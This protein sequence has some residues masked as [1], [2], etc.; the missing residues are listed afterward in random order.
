M[1]MACKISYMKNGTLGDRLKRLRKSRRL[2]Q[3]N[4][5]DA[6]GI[7][8]PAVVRWEAD[9]SI[10]GSQNLNNLCNV[11]NTTH[12]YLMY[13]IS[14]GRVEDRGAEYNGTPVQRA[15]PVVDWP[16]VQEAPKPLTASLAEHAKEHTTCPVPCSGLAFALNVFGNSMAAVS[17]LSVPEG[18]LIIVD[19]LKRTHL[20]HG[21]LVI[22]V[23]DKEKTLTFKQFETNGIEQWLKP[24]NPSY[25]VLHGAFTV[26]GKVIYAGRNL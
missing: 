22:A 20:H 4:I 8:A 23:I 3:K 7:S 21:D 5:A 11:L 15:I 14:G 19:P 6:L 24:L 25:P 17:G 10:P 12:E 9:Q 13:G 2:T 18:Y 26:V 1:S 16:S